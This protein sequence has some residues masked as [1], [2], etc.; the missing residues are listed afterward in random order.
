VRDHEPHPEDAADLREPAEEPAGTLRADIS[1]E[2]V[3][4]Y[5]NYYGKGPVRCRTYLQ[6]ELVTVVLGGGYTRSEQT[7][8][9]DGKWHEV[10][11]ARQVWQD[12]MQE[13]FV[14]LIERQTGRK[15]AAFLSA[16]HQA[17]DFAVE[18]FVLEPEPAG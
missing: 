5:K 11:R 8:F 9:E 3:R 1:R 4:L 6:P 12:S 13:R 17:P 14:E 16:N 7:L 2:M 18:L 15:V 10:R